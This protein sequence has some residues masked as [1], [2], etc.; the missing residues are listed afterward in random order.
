MRVT[1]ARSSYIV[2][3]VTV[4]DIRKVSAESEEAATRQPI[5]S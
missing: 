5:I 4:E 2:T 1:V 3:A